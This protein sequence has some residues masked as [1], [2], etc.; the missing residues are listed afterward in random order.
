MQTRRT[1][2][3]IERWGRREGLLRNKDKC[4]ILT[5][6]KKSE[7]LASWEIEKKSIYGIPFVKKYKYLGVTL[8]KKLNA[9]ANL[10]DIEEKLSRYEKM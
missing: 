7:N 9:K 5:F 6:S 8:N 3:I 10:E 4:G 2:K 1:I